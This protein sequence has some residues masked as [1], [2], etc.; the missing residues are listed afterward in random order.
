MRFLSLLHDAP[1]GVL[2]ASEKEVESSSHPGVRFVIRRCSAA[3]RLELIQ[4]LAEHAG[5]YEALRSTERTDDRLRA[6]ALRLRMDFEY[7]DWGLA[8]VCG[9]MVDG[10]APDVRRLFERGPEALVREIVGRI[11]EECELSEAERKN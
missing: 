9:L 11:R 8:R 4:R 5:E 2:Y 1:D 6:E 3:R 10:E 7:L